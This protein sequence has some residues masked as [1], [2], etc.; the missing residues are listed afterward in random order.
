MSV[1][2]GNVWRF[3]TT[4]FEN[5]GGAF[6]VPYFTVLIFIGKVGSVVPNVSFRVDRYKLSDA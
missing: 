3:P 1:G 5:G 4:A 6:L 2:L